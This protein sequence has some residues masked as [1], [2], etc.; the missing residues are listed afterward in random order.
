[1]HT[2][3]TRGTCSHHIEFDVKDD[4][5][6]TKV[7]FI[8]GCTGNTQGVAKLV[9]GKNIDEVISLLKGI[10]CRAGTSCPDQLATALIKYKEKNN[11]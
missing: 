5:T 11:L 9:E 10:Q 1:M 7:K 4:N 8:G 3:T 2:Y 6:L